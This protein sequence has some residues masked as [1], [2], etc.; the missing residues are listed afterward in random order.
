M[1]IILSPI[2]K[3]HIISGI[4]KIVNKQNVY[5]QLLYQKKLVINLNLD[6]N[7]CI[8]LFSKSIVQ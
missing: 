7:Q 2:E 1:N 3:I 5:T 8:K 4:K 6:L